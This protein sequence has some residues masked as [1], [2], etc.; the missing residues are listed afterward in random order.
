MPREPIRVNTQA[1]DIIPGMKE[2]PPVYGLWRCSYVTM[3][4]TGRMHEADQTV[5]IVFGLIPMSS[6]GYDGKVPGKH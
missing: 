3:K 4:S 5:Y 2:P 6:I 1:P